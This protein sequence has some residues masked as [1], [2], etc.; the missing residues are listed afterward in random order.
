MSVLGSLFRNIAILGSQEG[1]KKTLTETLFSDPEPDRE[2]VLETIE[3]ERKQRAL[4]FMGVDGA[5]VYPYSPFDD[6]PNIVIPSPVLQDTAQRVI[7]QTTIVP[8]IE[9]APRGQVVRGLGNIILD[10]ERINANIASIQ[11]ALAESSIIEKRYRDS[12]IKDRRQKVS[13]TGKSRSQERAGR[14]RS[15]VLARK[16]QM[17]LR[18]LGEKVKRPAKALADAALFGLG[19]EVA[20]FVLETTNDYAKAGIDAS[21]VKADTPYAKALIASVREVEGTAGPGGTGTFFGGSQ[22]GGDLT[23]KTVAEVAQIQKKFLD[24]G[25]GSFVDP[26]TG[27][28]RQSAAVGIGQFLYPE[29]V[30]RDMGLDPTKVKFTE[31]LQNQM[32]LFLA[33]KRDVDYNKQ[34][35][36][37]DIRKL[38]PEWAG[39]GGIHGQSKRTVKQSLEIYQQNLE[40]VRRSQSRTPTPTGFTMPD[41]SK[42][43]AP[44]GGG[45]NVGDVIGGPQGTLPEAMRPPT[46][47]PLQQPA[48]ATK[49]PEMPA[50]ASA[51]PRR[52]PIIIDMRTAKAPKVPP[53]VAAYTTAQKVPSSEPRLVNSGYESIFAV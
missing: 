52:G 11:K 16:S 15:A 51:P 40:E 39:F 8:E 21:K 23:G 7:P 25:Q 1:A 2:S 43:G 34:L 26:K 42:T 37:A 33:A 5:E 53:A 3:E 50:V 38:Q 4:S 45:Y 14:R 13:Q 20:N 48:V 49:K 9:P 41:A 19:L 36:E 35:T 22:Y 10:I 6:A 24:E 29:K 47:S 44:A 18:N 30:V 46:P 12:L 28:R 17:P 27:K 31:E 32:I